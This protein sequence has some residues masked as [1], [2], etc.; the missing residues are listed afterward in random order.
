MQGLCMGQIEISNPL[1]PT[2]RIGWKE[3][4]SLRLLICMC[5]FLAQRIRMDHKTD[6][7]KFTMR[8]TGAPHFGQ[9]DQPRDLVPHFS[10][11]VL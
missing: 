5:V 11:D 6:R 3:W 8:E 4:Q 9:A 2:P 7:N 10:S 1:T